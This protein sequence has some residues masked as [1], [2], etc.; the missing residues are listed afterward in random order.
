MSALAIIDEIER[1]ELETNNSWLSMSTF[2]DLRTGKTDEGTLVEKPSTVMSTA[3]A[4]AVG[5]SAGLDAHYFGSGKMEGAHVARQ[6]AGTLAKDN[7]DDIKKIRH[8]FD[9]VVKARAKN[10][11][12]WQ[13]CWEARRQIGL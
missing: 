12:A 2:H 4:V 13:S 11:K 8:Y 9:A 7:P 3:E 1:A 6:L 10:S 5:F